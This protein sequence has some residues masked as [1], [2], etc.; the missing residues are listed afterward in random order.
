MKNI[1]ITL[2]VLILNSQTFAK[3]SELYDRALIKDYIENTGTTAEPLIQVQVLGGAMAAYN[4]LYNVDEVLKLN[5]IIIKQN[6]EI[7]RI[8]KKH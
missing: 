1:V 2:A 7:L 6:E 3:S 4:T 8:F 5:K